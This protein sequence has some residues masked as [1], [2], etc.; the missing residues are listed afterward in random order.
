M[1]SGTPDTDLQLLVARTVS[2][3]SRKRQKFGIAF[4][5]NKTYN[6]ILTV[7]N[8]YLVFINSGTGSKHPKPYKLAKMDEKKRGTV[9][10][11][12]LASI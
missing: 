8:Y 5:Y 6:S 7:H 12:A 11:L 2:R 3:V 4:I 10:S 1:F 9:Q